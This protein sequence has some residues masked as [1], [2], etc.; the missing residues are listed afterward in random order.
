MLGEST[1]TIGLGLGGCGAAGGF[2]GVIMGG[3][4]SD[5]LRARNESGRIIVVAFGLLTPIIPIVLAF[6]T[7]ND[8][9]SN[10]DFVRFA[11]FVSLANML[12]SSALGAAAATT[13]D[14]VMPRMRG[15]ATATF[16]LATTLFGLAL[17]PYLAG[18]MS[19]ISGSLSIGVLSILVIVPVGI[20]LLLAAYRAV[21]LAERTVV[22]RARAAGEG[23]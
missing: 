11:V 21:P 12:A 1:A 3:R 4:M 18:Q 6:T 14:L 22:E 10:M 13:Q 8:P 9:D 2:I 7:V 5:W 20:V 15:T 19:V 16:F 17:G 23:V